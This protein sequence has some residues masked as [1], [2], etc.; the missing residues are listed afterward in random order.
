M[1]RKFSI[2]FLSGLSMWLIIFLLRKNGIIIPVINNYL[3]D[4]ITIPMYA[5]LI[6]YIVNKIPGFRWKPDLKF[7]LTSILYISFLFE[8]FCPMISDR[9]TGDVFDIVAYSIGGLGYYFFRKKTSVI[10]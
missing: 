4:L 1:D 3:T 2:G 7:I 5:Y 10:S 9:F 6:E 8:V